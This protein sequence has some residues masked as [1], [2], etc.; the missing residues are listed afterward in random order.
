MHNEL[1][2]MQTS[3]LNPACVVI[4]I[5]S[6]SNSSADSDMRFVRIETAEQVGLVSAAE[7]SAANRALD[8]IETPINERV[9]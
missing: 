8:A 9:W 7:R 1:I 6:D 4:E 2:V 3:A 5:N